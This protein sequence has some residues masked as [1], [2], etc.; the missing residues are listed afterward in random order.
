MKKDLREWI[1][2]EVKRLEQE[3][4]GKNS[5]NAE[6]DPVPEEL[7]QALGKTVVEDKDS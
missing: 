5:Y 1:D 2:K 4:E 7:K 6:P 3:S